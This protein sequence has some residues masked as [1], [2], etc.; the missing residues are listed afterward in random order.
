MLYDLP[1][2]LDFL[3]QVKQIL[4]NDGIFVAQVMDLVS[5][6]RANAF[7]NI[8]FEH[9]EYYTLSDL[10]DLCYLVGL[11]IFDVDY[12][13]VNGGSV[14][15]YVAHEGSREINPKVSRAL[16]DEFEFF[17]FNTLKDFAARIKRVR[18]IV[19]KEITKNGPV[20]VMGAS[21]KGNTM[22]QYWK[23]DSSNISHA[24]EVNPDKFGK[25]TIGTNIPIISDKESL[26]SKPRQYLLLPWHF[27]DNFIIKYRSYLDNGGEFL[28]PLP[29]PMTIRVEEGKVKW[30]YLNE[31]LV[32]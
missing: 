29:T 30:T 14:R 32:S 10:I 26:D 6:I 15:I 8:C 24:A 16:Q 3:G 17:R 18:D 19:V 13:D 22:L 2:P 5:M 9:L 28:V 4:D 1:K 21:T 11:E 27:L 7:D 23:L 31:T 12:N 20:A 25:R